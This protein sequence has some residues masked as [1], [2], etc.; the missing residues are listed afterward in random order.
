MLVARRRRRILKRTGLRTPDNSK[1]VGPAMPRSTMRVFS[2]TRASR[3]SHTSRPLVVA[4]FARLYLTSNIF[5][6]T[7]SLIRTGIRRRHFSSEAPSSQSGKSSL[8]VPLI[9]RL[10]A[11]DLRI[12]AGQRRAVAN[13][14]SSASRPH[15]EPSALV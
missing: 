2:G 11:W 13:P 1:T 3:R 6:Q 9:R 5:P 4:D 14:Q 12:S 7:S 15:Q 8:N 10:I